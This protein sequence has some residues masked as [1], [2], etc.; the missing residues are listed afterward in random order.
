M[1]TIL[2]AS[3]GSSLKPAMAAACARAYE[4]P[5]LRIEIAAGEHDVNKVVKC[6]AE[7]YLPLPQTVIPFDSI[8]LSEYDLVVCFSTQNK[9]VFPDMPGNPAVVYWSLPSFLGKSDSIPNKHECR[10]LYEKIR[11]LVENLMKQGYLPALSQARK[12]AELVMD[13][14]HEGIIAHD[15]NRK[16]FF[17]NRAAERITGYDRSEILGRDCHDVFPDRF[18]KSECSFCDISEEPVEIQKQY[19]VVISSKSGE[20]KHI[21]MSVV[22]IKNFLDN[23]V[24]VV[25]SFRDVSREYELASRLEGVEQFAGIIGKDAAMQEI[26]RTIKDLGKSNVSVLLQGESGTGKELVAAAIHNKGDRADKLF[27]PVNCGALPENL[28]ESELFGHVKGAFTGAIRDKKGRFELADGGTIFLD[29]IG[30]ITPSMQV[31]LLRILQDGIFQRVGDEKNCK[32]DVRVISATHKNL[33][34]EIAEGRFR[35]D[36]YYRLCVV[37]VNLPPLRERRSD[38]PLLARHFLNKAIQEEG[39]GQVL[40]SPDTMDQ[41]VSYNW[42]GNVRELQNVVRYLLVQCQE[43]FIK[44]AHLPPA[45]QEVAKRKVRVLPSVKRKSKL[46][47][48]SVREA[49]DAAGGNRAKAARNLGVGRATLYRF[50]AKHP[51]N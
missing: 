33:K 19:P 25:A 29:E 22:S 46:T 14:L 42:P 7:I 35:E 38:I 23:P 31:K 5:S 16:I 48:E 28:L 40:F 21:E 3:E 50:L 44:P 9:P 24:G 34:K 37:P 43:D 32:V 49:I 26:F 51:L 17:F 12:N 13:N 36:L 1:N 11:G 30:D 10:S 15:I 18:C 4:M 47:P 45:L 8:I 6:L 27:V 41:L 39:R 2:F 20:T